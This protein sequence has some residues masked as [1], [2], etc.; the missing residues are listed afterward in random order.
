MGER[1]LLTWL[2]YCY[3]NFK[4][5]IW[6]KSEPSTRWIVNFDV[7]LTDSLV[8]AACLGAYCPFVIDDLLSR[9]YMIADSAVKCFHNALLLVEACRRIG[10][11]Y[12]LTSLDITDPNSISMLLF[13]AYLFNKLPCYIPSASIEFRSQLHVTSSKQVKITNPSAKNIFYQAFLCGRGA[14]D[15]SLPGGSELQI[16]PKGKLAV[17]VEFKGNNLKA[18]TC[19]LVL[20]GRKRNCLSPETLVFSLNAKIDELTSK[21]LFFL[22]FC[23][24]F[25]ILRIDLF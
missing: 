15:F 2:N 19:Y 23:L 1:I 5:K 25:V 16:L 10:L 12:D 4:S 11:D 22:F 17:S 18:R 6:P 13:C 21:V 3:A 14:E 8:L 7:D 9:M 24:N 20:V